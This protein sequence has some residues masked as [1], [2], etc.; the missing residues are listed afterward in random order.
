MMILLSIGRV[1]ALASVPYD[2]SICDIN[3]SH[4]LPITI[5]CMDFWSGSKLGFIRRPGCA[6]VGTKVQKVRNLI[7]IREVNGS[8]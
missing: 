5:C 1:I 7:V 3:P 4:C 2:P 6:R 8:R